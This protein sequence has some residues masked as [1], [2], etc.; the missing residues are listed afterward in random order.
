MPI[1]YIRDEL[2]E[3]WL[4][5]VSEL[6][7][8][9]DVTFPNGVTNGHALIY[10]SG[11][12]VW[13]SGS[14]GSGT[15]GVSYLADLLDVDAESPSSGD[16]LQY[17]TGTSK[18]EAVPQ[19]GSSGDMY[20][21]V[22]DQDNDGI[23][24]NAEMLGG[25]LPS[26]YSIAGHT[27]TGTYAPT[28]H[29]HW[30]LYYSV[31]DLSQSTGS[32]SVHWDRLT[33]KPSTY[34]PSTHTHTES[35]ITDLV[36]NAVQIDGRDIDIVGVPDDGNTL[37]WR[38]SENKWVYEY[39]SGS[40]GGSSS[41]S[42]GSPNFFPIFNES[43]ST[44]GSSFETAYSFISNTLRVTWNG[45][46]Q[47]ASQFSEG[48]DNH[49]FT[50][51]FTKSAD[52]SLVADYYRPATSGSIA[53]WWDGNALKLQN[54]DIST[55][56]AE[57]GQGLIW[58]SGENKWQPQDLV[59]GSSGSSGFSIDKN[60][61][62]IWDDFD[63]WQ[64]PLAYLYGSAINSGTALTHGASPSH[65]GVVALA[66][67]SS[68]GSSGYGYYT[69]S[70]NTWF[71]GNEEFLCIF[72]IAY[73]HSGVWARIGYQNNSGTWQYPS[74][75]AF[76][77]VLGRYA[78]GMTA[79]WPNRTSTSTGYTL[80]LNTYYSV[81]IIT[82]SDATRVDFYLYSSGGVE[83][84]SDYS[85]TDIPNVNGYQ[86]ELGFFGGCTYTPG[87]S[88]AMVAVDYFYAKRTGLVR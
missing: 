66:C 76:L 38:S 43:I 79:K 44:T 15:G 61:F 64:T 72:A 26:Y 5:V 70:H 30:G 58:N 27:H 62:F 56:E 71:G 87:S 17:N 85:T 20:K 36:H 22:Y 80:S 60:V 82:N 83:L 4:P 55:V 75:G 2:N 29:N 32:G 39:V 7:A 8:I 81:K 65:P 10:H 73:D 47:A 23:V 42:S 51:M 59:G 52:D 48:G 40:D 54:R 16:I 33:N 6:G 84:W 12:G 31:S 78:Y 67:S 28:D 37:V 46:R 13:T 3:Q 77:N 14:V 19:S 57:D 50:T 24:D 74:N 53:G 18:W 88:T 49:S 25:Q 21:S 34:T 68:S 41:G 35:Q 1:L 69:Q 45:V 86:H 9:P 63:R 11:S